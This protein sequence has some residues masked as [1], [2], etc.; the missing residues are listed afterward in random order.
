MLNT[1]NLKG[2]YMSGILPSEYMR[3]IGYAETTVYQYFAFNQS[4]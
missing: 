3:N 4:N 1:F 2:I